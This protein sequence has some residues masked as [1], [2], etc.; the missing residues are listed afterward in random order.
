MACLLND[1]TWLPFLSLEVELGVSC[2]LGRQEENFLSL[3]SS[4]LVLC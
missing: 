2:M 3:I 4:A 1:D